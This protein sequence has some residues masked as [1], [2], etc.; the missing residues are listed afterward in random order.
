MNKFFNHTVY[1]PFKTLLITFFGV[2]ILSLGISRIY[3]DNDLL[4]WF[5][6][7]SKIGELNYYINEKFE[8][9]NPIIVMFTLKNDV[10]SKENLKEIR[11]LSLRMEEEKGVANVISITEIEDIQGKE[12]EMSVSK[13]IPDNIDEVNVANL[14]EYIMSKESYKGSLI[15]KDGY[16]TILMIQPSQD[17]KSDSL[18]KDLRKKINQYL[19]EKNLE[20]EVYYGGT[21]M[22]LNSISDLVVKDLRFLIPLVSLV[23]FMVL[24]LSF[25][26]IKATLLPLITVLLATASAIGVMGYL[27]LPL[28]TFGVAIP[29]VLIAVGNAYGIHFINEYNEKANSKGKEEA[30]ISVHKR[31]FIPILMSAVTTF[32]GFLSIAVSND[33]L[34][35]RDFG[36]I[37]AI[38]VIFAFLITISFIPAMLSIFPKTKSNIGHL[39]EE[40]ENKI[41][42]S[43]SHFIF[44]N[45]KWVVISFIIFGIL[46]TYFITKVEIKVDY[47]SYFDKKSE[48]AIVTD[49]ISKIFDGVFELKLYSK[50]EMSA[51][52]LR[53]LKIIE[54]KLR[55]TAGGKTRPNS[56]VGIIESLNE[57]I[58]E[59]P[60][61]PDSDYEIENLW[62]FIEGNE[63]L[64]RLVTEDKKET[65]ISFLLPSMESS[66]RYKIVN[67]AEKLLK[68][69]STISLK[70][71]SQCEEEVKEF[72]SIS[73]YNKLI[74]SDI[75]ID[76][77]KIKDFLDKN[78]DFKINLKD[79]ESK[80][81]FLNK[82]SKR[83]FEEFPASKEIS[84]KDLIEALS[85]LVWD[86]F[87]TPGDEV[88]IFENYGVAGLMKLFTDVENT[89][90]RNQLISLIV[91]VIIVVFLNT[92]T[93][94]SMLEGVFS[95]I[96]ILFTLIVNFGIMGLFKINMDFITTTIAAISVGAGIDYTIHFLSRYTHEVENK[97]NYE[98]AFYHTFSTTGKGIIFNAL[99][100]GLGF[101]VL[102]FSG[103]MPLRN[104]GTLMLVTMLISSFS[105]LTLLPVL[106]FYFRKKI[107]KI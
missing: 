39:N 65:L 17:T 43:V 21:P 94:K 30:L 26:S 33:M 62:F 102:N 106:T 70:D 81:T 51:N 82:I 83:F 69:Y 24:F 29:V 15:S 79:Y 107:L 89:L 76:K 75:T 105:A 32:A 52:Y 77:D 99:S 101:A 1:K 11:E 66:T 80:K 56:I 87:V 91:I 55:Y 67:E 100:V 23:V 103:I 19:K 20:W 16:S 31:V 104:F 86:K 92:I 8:T 27:G 25:R 59:V 2:I 6:K 10:L 63:N 35:A 72:V 57:G 28:T 41:F 93:F 61:I 22:L 54:E 18:A 42:H 88:K 50:G 53:T 9:N 5:S 36:I 73:I 37:S 71:I 7:K 34:S 78:V 58:T 74:R 90:L 38:G 3:L 97:K 95:L 14:K 64:K 98:E 46:A 47:M 48:P 68:L 49:K 60:S 84:K 96:P 12:D 85:P 40:V 45:K 44:K 4:H 13:L